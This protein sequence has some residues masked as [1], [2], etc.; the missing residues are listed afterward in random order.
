MI[1]EGIAK[2][3]DAVGSQG[4]LAGKIGRAQSTVSD[5]LNGNKKVSPE[6]VPVI[7]RIAEGAVLPHEIRPDLPELFP[8]PAQD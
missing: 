7:V 3:V 8:H 4:A 1:N 6:I 5:W 2:A